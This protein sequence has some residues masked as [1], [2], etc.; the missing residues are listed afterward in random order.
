M[1]ISIFM[2]IKMGIAYDS[3]EAVCVADQVMEII[4]GEA[5]R[6]SR[7]LAHER[8]I[9]PYWKG[10]V[11][12][13]SGQ[14]LRNAT[15]TAVAPTGSISIIAGVNPG[16]EPLFALSYR[17]SNVLEGRTLYEFSPLLDD[18]AHDFK[19]DADRVTKRIKEN[20][21][22]AGLADIPPKMRR[23]LKTALEIPPEQHLRIQHAFQRRV[24]NAVSK[25][26]NLPQNA[27]PA[28]IR[29]IYQRAWELGLKGITVYRYGS[30]TSQVFETDEGRTG[31][32]IQPASC[33]E[34]P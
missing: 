14:R 28:D 16:I 1:K 20:A 25:T 31:G 10:S 7:R 11:H 24:D 34:C 6:T 12:Q 30:K 8:G 33:K 4:S 5:L 2:L 26:V 19:I 18:L 9:Y 15:R 32:D 29:Q 17:R 22:P 3:Q 21:D 27:V 23:I 13:K